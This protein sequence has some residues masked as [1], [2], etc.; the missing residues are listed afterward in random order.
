MNPEFPAMVRYASERDIR[1]VTSTNGHF[2]NNEDYLAEVLSSGL[3]TMIVAIDSLK[4]I[5]Y[6]A[7]RHKG[8]VDKAISGLEKAVKMKKKL[9]SDTTIVLRMMIMKQNEDELEAM[10]DFAKAMK[11][12]IFAVKTVYPTQGLISAGEEFLP[13]NPKYR[14]YIYK[15]GTN[16]PVKA[17][18]ECLYVW[19]SSNIFTNGNVASCCRDYDAEYN[20]GNVFKTPFSKIWHGRAYREFRKRVYLNKSSFEKCRNCSINFQL[21]E[22]GWFPETLDL[23][24]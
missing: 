13:D 11:V 24:H 9:G 20:L 10:R 23:R 12:D 22:S 4:Q 17:V 16:E 8:S 15:K 7:Y 18:G 2:L 6:D 3:T 1:T 5:G 19:H 21:S 14:R